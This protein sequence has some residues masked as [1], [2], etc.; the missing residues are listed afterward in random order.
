[1]LK[2][3]QFLRRNRRII[4]PTD[5]DP[6]HLGTLTLPPGTTLDGK[7]YLVISHTDPAMMTVDSSVVIGAGSALPSIVTPIELKNMPNLYALLFSGGT[8][9]VYIKTEGTPDVIINEVMWAV[10]ENAV[11]AEGQDK[12]QWIELYNTSDTVVDS[13]DITLRFQQRS[14]APSTADISN[15]GKFTDRLSNVLRVK[16]T[17]GWRLGDNHGQ[18]GNSNATS[19]KEFSSM[20]RKGDKRGNAD[21]INGEYWIESTIL[22]HVNHK[23]TPGAENTIDQASVSTRATPRRYT[24]PKDSVIINEVYNAADDKFDWIELR[25]LNNVNIRNWTLSYA[26]SDFTEVEIMRFPNSNRTINAGTILLIVNADPRETNLAAGQDITLGDAN[27]ARGAGSHKYWN[28]SNGNSGSSS[29]LDIPDYNGGDFLLILRKATGNN[30]ANGGWQR[31]GSGDRIHDVVGTGTFVKQTL[32]KDTLEYE[33]HTADKNAGRPDG[34]IWNTRVWPLNDQNLGDYHKDKDTLLQNDRNLAVGNVLARSGERDGW[35]KDGIYFPGNRGGHGYDRGVVAN[36]TPGYDNGIRKN[37]HTDLADGK[38]VVSE[39]MLTTDSGRYPQWIELHNTS[40]TN[41]VD[42]YADTDGSSSSSRQGWS[43]R[44]ENHRS[45]SWDSRR[46]DKL[47]VEVRFKDLGV[48]YIQPNQT[49]LITADKVRNSASETKRHFPDHRVASI[50][51]TGARDRFKMENRRDTFLNAEGGFLLEIVDGSNQV[52][53]AV[54]NLD[55]KKPDIFDTENVD[56]D[57]PYSWNWPTDMKGN[58]RTSLI[59]KYDDRVPRMGTPDRDVEGNMRG[60]PAPLG[61]AVGAGE[62]GTMYSWVHAADT[63]TARAQITWYGSEDDYGTPGHTTST[64]LPVSLSYFR[65]TLENGEVVIRWTTESELDN[66][67]FNILRSDSRNG[68]FKQVNSELVQGAGTTGER[69]TYKWVDESAKP[70]VIYYYQIED[71][72]F[73]GE[74]QT[75]TTTK[76]KG[77]IS[78]KNKLTTLWG[79]LKEVQ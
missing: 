17:T 33:P 37:K 55:G 3:F 47:N 22:S 25:F 41:T 43:I 20:Y 1:M 30:N 58:R 40:M 79:G 68:E 23:G 78:A 9:D 10:D 59:R 57:D 39:L 74:H 71:V 49:I 63:K 45:G 6:N 27:Q 66:A 31:Y 26:K 4:T 52:S 5:Q 14:P 24:P 19:P 18:N 42:L 8:I 2:S 46:K 7:G 11:G 50:W 16:T 12:H 48:Q 65:P 54:G 60:A 32:E 62:K 61:T 38:V 72:S 29:Y 69:N 64:P 75:L 70:G 13:G 51:A 21:G 36:G 53:D 44:V 76:L 35:K 28:P 34:Y 15:K 67:G 73:A 77:L 56:F